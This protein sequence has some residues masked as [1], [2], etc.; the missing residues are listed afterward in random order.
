M[1]SIADELTAES[2]L[3]ESKAENGGNSP[4]AK[5]EKRGAGRRAGRPKRPKAENRDT[6]RLGP[7]DREI[8]HNLSGRRF[9]RLLALALIIRESDPGMRYWLCACDCGNFIE[10]T[11]KALLTRNPDFLSCGRCKTPDLD[12]ALKEQFPGEFKIWERVCIRHRSGQRKGGKAAKKSKV[13]VRWL[14]SF[15]AFL[16]DMGTRPS[17]FLQLILTKR[18]AVRS[19]KTCVWGRRSDAPA[20]HGDRWLMYQGKRIRGTDFVRVYGARK[21]IFDMCWQ[22]F[23]MRDG[24]EIMAYQVAWAERRERRKAE[25]ATKRNA[26]I[27][28]ECDPKAENSPCSSPTGPERG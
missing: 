2:I 26:G 25:R 15:A 19:R 12:D 7:F 22:K 18:Y 4:D 20:A 23:G 14:N 17:E 3:T 6:E 11:A 27:A 16:E 21:M 1:S 5:A 13:C 28:A 24:D 9:S 8:Q 10:A